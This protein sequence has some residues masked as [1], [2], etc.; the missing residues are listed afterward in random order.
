MGGQ[1]CR[2]QISHKMIERDSRDVLI[3]TSFSAALL[4][5]TMLLVCCTTKMPAHF[6]SLQSRD[7]FSMFRES[8]GKMKDLPPSYD[9]IVALGPPIK[10]PTRQLGQSVAS[11]C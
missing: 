10:Q 2:Q 11:I 9:D 8:S 7:F 6:A 4:F 1:T 3:I 5:L